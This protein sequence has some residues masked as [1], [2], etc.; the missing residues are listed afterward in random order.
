MVDFNDSDNIKPSVF[1]K[2]EFCSSV[3]ANQVNINV[4]PLSLFAKFNFVNWPASVSTADEIKALM[5][6]AFRLKELIRLL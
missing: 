2:I 5:L 1:K 6:K 3:Q 4:F